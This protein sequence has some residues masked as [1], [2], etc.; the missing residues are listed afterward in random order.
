[1]VRTGPANLHAREN[2]NAKL[3]AMEEV[4]HAGMVRGPAEDCASKQDHM[5]WLE[6]K[7]M[8][9]RVNKPVALGTKQIYERCKQNDPCFELEHIGDAAADGCGRAGVWIET[10]GAPWLSPSMHA[11]TCD[12]SCF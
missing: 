6:C 7:A 3:A 12:R 10:T 4:E 1:M 9:Q 8:D 5:L 11:A 2:R